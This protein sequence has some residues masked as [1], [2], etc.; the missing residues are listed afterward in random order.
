MN[1]GGF[2]GDLLIRQKTNYMRTFRYKWQDVSIGHLYV[3]HAGYGYTQRE[4]RV[5]N[6]GMSVTKEQKKKTSKNNVNIVVG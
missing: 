2:S 1:S 5:L 3:R 4:E 6:Y